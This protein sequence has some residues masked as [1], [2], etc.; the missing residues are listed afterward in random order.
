MSRSKT[1]YGFDIL[2]FLMALVVI[3][4]HAQLIKVCGDNHTLY[5]LWNF[6]ND[7]AVPVFFV[8][9][10]YFLF[11]KLRFANNDA[12]GGIVWSYT[13][14]LLKL[15]AFWCIVLLPI[16]LGFW[17]KEY[18]NSPV[19]VS[20]ILFFKNTLFAYQFGAS[21]FLGALLI[22]VPLTWILQKILGDKFFWIIPV[23]IYFYLYIPLSDKEIYLWYEEN[24]RYPTTSFPAGLLWIAIGHYLSHP[25]V[26]KI[27]DVFNY[28]YY[29]GLFV[30]MCLVST[31]QPEYQYVFRIPGVVSLIVF[32]YKMPKSNAIW[33]PW[34]RPCSTLFYCPHYSM[35]IVFTWL[36]PFLRAH[37]FL[38]YITVL[39]CLSLM[40]YVI[41]KLKDR[42]KLNLLKYAY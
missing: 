31:L 29:F 36:S 2:K 39:A 6:I 21:W 7:C 30:I 10:S 4:I 3:N 23:V 11:K 22:G 17:H 41:L 8:L 20:L 19:L 15:Y 13:L 35:I 1:I 18:I 34:M 16:I 26:V 28:R 32:A 24:L 42:P 12:G 5:A 40:S 25:K 33:K 37:T 38:L 14:R 9:S 27:I